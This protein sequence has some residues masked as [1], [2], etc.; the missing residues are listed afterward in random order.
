MYSGW[1]LRLSTNLNVRVKKFNNSYANLEIN[2]Q[3]LR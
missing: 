2:Y 3:G 1:V